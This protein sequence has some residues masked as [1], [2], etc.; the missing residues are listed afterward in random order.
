M[1]ITLLAYGQSD[2]TMF[3]TVATCFSQKSTTIR[4]VIQ[5]FKREAKFKIKDTH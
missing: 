3:I 5:L 2:T 4:L 1:A